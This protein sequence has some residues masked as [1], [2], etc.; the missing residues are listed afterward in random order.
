MNKTYI[1]FSSFK[2]DVFTLVFPEGMAEQ[3]VPLFRNFV[4]NGLIQL[5]TFCDSYQLFNVGFYDKDQSFD[6]CG[7]SLIQACR[8]QIGAV[9]AFKPSCKCERYFYDSASLE[10]LSCLYDNCK[11]ANT[12]CSPNHLF[13]LGA[14]TQDPYYCGVTVDGNTGCKPP[15]L[16]AQPEDDCA[17]KVADRIFAIGP[18]NKLWL[19]PRFPCGYVVAVHWRGIP[20]S[21][22]DTDWVLDD[23]DLKD[24]VACYV[25]SELARRVDKDQATGDKLLLDYRLKAQD[26][27][28]REERDLKPR[29]TRTC[30][31]GIDRSELTQMYPSNP[32]P[33]YVGYQ[34]AQKKTVNS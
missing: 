34:C 16:S 30:V 17:F 8:G 10:K 4:V 20:R 33:T 15:Y 14:Y 3:R 11:C 23:D 28:F 31:E 22:L 13:S 6:D 7:T 32:Y 29:A 26:I 1:L 9:Y 27:I 5:T 18:G 21:Y 12:G 24:A 2:R 25:E 19:Y